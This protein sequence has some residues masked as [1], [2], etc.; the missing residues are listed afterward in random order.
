[1]HHSIPHNHISSRNL[2]P[3]EIHP[4]IT[5]SNSHGAVG[6]RVKHLPIFKKGRIADVVNN[7]VLAEDG[8]DLLVRQPGSVDGR[9]GRVLGREDGDAGRRGDG[10]DEVELCQEGR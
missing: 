2:G 10:L 9:E 8:D 3:V 5:N 4:T 6:E 1:M 7:N